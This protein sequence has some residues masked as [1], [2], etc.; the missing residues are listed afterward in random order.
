MAK[1]SEEMAP[2]KKVS[3]DSDNPIVE[4]YKEELL[5]RPSYGIHPAAD[6]EVRLCRLEGILAEM[7]DK[8]EDLEK[9]IKTIESGK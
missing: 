7:Q 4:E 1:K 6:D 8:L 5:N 9:R 3:R 2:T